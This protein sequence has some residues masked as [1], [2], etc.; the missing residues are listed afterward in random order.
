MIR[1]YPR[2]N[3]LHFQYLWSQKF[4][5]EDVI[6]INNYLEITSFNSIGFGGMYNTFR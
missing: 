6:L 2:N 3:N 1:V 4:Q 5:K